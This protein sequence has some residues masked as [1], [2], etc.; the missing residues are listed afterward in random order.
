MKDL[1]GSKTFAS[2]D[3]NFETT[4]HKTYKS[5]STCPGGRS[6]EQQAEHLSPPLQARC[7]FLEAARN[8]CWNHIVLLDKVIRTARCQS[9]EVTLN[10]ECRSIRCVRNCRMRH[11]LVPV[12]H[13]CRLPPFA[14][15]QRLYHV[16][17]H[18]RSSMLYI[19]TSINSVNGQASGKLKAHKRF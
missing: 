3:S 1:A 6:S 15:Q 17:L 12:V 7:A 10:D 14:A 5:I 19:S 8:A 13:A 11:R 4:F 18:P 2:Y 9:D 16:G